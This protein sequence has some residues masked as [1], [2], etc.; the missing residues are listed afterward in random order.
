MF[1]VDE[2]GSTMDPIQPQVHT[3]MEINRLHA[4]VGNLVQELYQVKSQ[5]PEWSSK[6]AL[7][8]SEVAS[9][10]NLAIKYCH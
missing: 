3:L 1:R 8:E 9:L 7:L 5:V 2:Q 10:K 6:V 4:Q